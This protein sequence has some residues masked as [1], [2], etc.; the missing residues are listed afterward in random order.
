MVRRLIALLILASLFGAAVPGALA[1]DLTHRDR[2]FEIMTRNMDGGSDFLYVLNAAQTDPNNFPGLLAAITQ[3]YLEMHLSNIPQRADGIAAEIQ[4]THPLLVGLQEV[5]VLRTGPYNEPATTVLD[6]GFASLMTALRNRGLHYAP[7]VVQAN[8]DI[9]LPA[10][11]STFQNLIDVRLTD[12]DVVLAR[13]DVSTANFKLQGV[14]AKHFDA[15]LNFPVAGQSI[16]FTRGWIAVDAKIRGKNF[17]FVTTHLETFSPDYQQA[18]TNELLWGPL[19][20]E[21]PVILAGDLN[22]DAL[23]PSWANGPAYGILTSAGFLD[24]WSV[25]HPNDAGVTWPMH[26]ED[27]PYGSTVPQRIDLVLVKN[28]GIVPTAVSLTGK[29]P[30]DDLWSSDHAGVVAGFKLLP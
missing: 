26:Q 15:I 12:Y 10:L 11:D 9:T 7:I 17:R 22:S 30:I 4:N 5:T 3:T 24:V 27:P 23:L 25:L 8:A 1:G 13:T 18:Q 19:K 2:N 20:T 29:M 14:Q 16:P 6:D 28:E 21:L